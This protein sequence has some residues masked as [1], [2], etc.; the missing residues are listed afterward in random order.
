MVIDDVCMVFVGL[1]MFCSSFIMDVNCIF[2]VF[3]FPLGVSMFFSNGFKCFFFMDFLA[4]SLLG[5]F[6]CVCWLVSPPKP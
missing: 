4:C 5:L 1:F 6:D 3:F 2:N